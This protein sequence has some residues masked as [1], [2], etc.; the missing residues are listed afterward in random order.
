MRQVRSILRWVSAASRKCEIDE[1]QLGDDSLGTGAARTLLDDDREQRVR[2]RRDGV[3]A[4]VGGV[5][6]LYHPERRVGVAPLG[7]LLDE[8]RAERD[9]LWEVGG[10]GSLTPTPSDVAFCD[11]RGHHPPPPA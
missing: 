9:G 2:A 10:L 3:D 7:N 1:M 6:G 4:V 8:P 11:W 5:F